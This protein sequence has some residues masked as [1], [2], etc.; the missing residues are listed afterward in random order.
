MKSDS[1]QAIFC[2]R[3][4]SI[5]WNLHKMSAAPLQCS[6]LLIKEKV[7]CLSLCNCAIVL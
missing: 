2:F 7:L 3:L 1:E 5:S 4:D 6:V